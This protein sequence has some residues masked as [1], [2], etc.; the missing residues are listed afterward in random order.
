M[1]KHINITLKV[2]RQKDAQDKG[3]LETYE[4]KNISGHMSFLEMLDVVNEQLVV[5]GV[6]PIHFDHDC[7]EGICGTCSLVIN[8]TPHG[9]QKATTT[10]QLHMRHY[11]D[12]DTIYIEPFRAKAFPVIKDLVVD[13]EPFYDKLYAVKPY[14]ITRTP[15]PSDRERYQSPEDREKL[16]GKYEC[17]LCGCCTSSCPTYWADK[18]FLGPNA[19]LKAS[20][21]MLDSR[22]EGFEDRV[23]CID[24]KHGIWRCHTIFNCVEACPKELNPTKGIVELRRLMMRGRL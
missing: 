22:D 8:G 4:A 19:L 3:R 13:M 15:P 18:N 23:N 10:C 17:I 1:S 7:R 5:E 6:D 21:F 20:K 24:D 11:K 14:L 2:W 9:H 16:D 12:G